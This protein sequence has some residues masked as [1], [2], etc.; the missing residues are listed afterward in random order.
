MDRR[1]FV[2]FHIKLT[3]LLQNTFKSLC[4]FG[5]KCLKFRFMVQEFSVQ[6]IVIEKHLL[7]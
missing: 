7:I 4:T 2:A 3:F 5:F 1:I 6:E